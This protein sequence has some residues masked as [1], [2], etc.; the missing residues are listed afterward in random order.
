MVGR[1]SLVANGDNIHN[2]SLQRFVLSVLLDDVLVSANV[3]L[4]QMSHHRYELY[5]SEK[6]EDRRQQAGLDIMVQDN[7]SGAQRSAETL[8][9]GESF[10]AA[11][12]LALGLSDTVQSYSGGIRLD[13]LFIDEGFGSLDA[14]S[15]ENAI[16]ILLELKE[17]GRM[18]GIISHVESIKQM[19][20]VKLNVMSA[21]G[22]SHTSMTTV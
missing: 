4:L 21:R 1:L 12:A 15:L 7:I 14:E 9:G 11:L 2:T 13:T 3:R 17:S 5:R 19:I 18:V 10:Q 20:D 16:N 6:V 8:S 22:I